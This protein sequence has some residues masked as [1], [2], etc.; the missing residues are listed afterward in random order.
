MFGNVCAVYQIR[1]VQYVAD[2][3][4]GSP[5]GERGLPGCRSPPPKTPKNQNLKNTDFV[6]MVISNVL[7]DFPFSQNQPLKAADD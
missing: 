1:A 2:S 4:K 7:P 6:D 3:A 5:K